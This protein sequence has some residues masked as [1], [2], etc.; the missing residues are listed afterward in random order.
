MQLIINFVETKILKKILIPF[1]PFYWILISLKN[2]LYDLNILNTYSLNKPVISLGNLTTGGTGKT[3][4]TIFITKYFIKHGIKV[5]I[6]SRGYGRKSKGT[7]VVSDG[8]KLLN[9]YKKTG[10]EPYLI[11]K[12]LKNIPIVVDKDRFR[13]GTYLITKFNPDII[14]LDDGYQHRSLKRDLNILLINSLDKKNDHKLIPNGK[15]REPWE[16]FKRANLII[17]TKSNLIKK[18]KFLIDKINK[19]KINT[20]NSEFHIKISEQFTKKAFKNINLS[21]KNILTVTA[22]GDPISFIESIKKMNCNIIKQINFKDHYNYNQK[23]W[24]KIEN[25]V[26]KFKIDFILT[27][28]KD[29]VKIEP[30]VINVPIIIFELDII[31]NNTKKFYKTLNNLIN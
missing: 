24:N 6:L 2:K 7:I 9:S 20:F 5:G 15:L 19:T 22:I 25:I 8:I 31:I 13:G 21:N 12:K 17:K 23:I 30:L 18:N 16:N 1:K 10:D 26:K 29:W 28:E 3:P 11:A 4:F 14:I 27:T